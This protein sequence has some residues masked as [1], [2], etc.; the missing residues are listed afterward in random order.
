M[1]HKPLRKDSI[2]IVE[3]E[4]RIASSISTALTGAGYDVTWVSDG[5][6]GLRTALSGGFDLVVL[7]V[8]LPGMKGFDIL[9]EL[10]AAGSPLLVLVLTS[11][12][13]VED[14][15]RGLTD[16]ADDYLTKPF[17]LEELMARIDALMRRIG[18]PAHEES[19]KLNEVKLRVGNVSLNRV[20][21]EVTVGG[22]KLEL[23][24]REFD[25]LVYLMR[26]PNAVRPRAKI[27]NALWSYGSQ[28]GDHVLDVYVGRLRNRLADAGAPGFIE[29]VRGVG[30]RVI[31]TVLTEG[32][33]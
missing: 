8:M 16:G 31:G 26:V 4:A 7:D 11:R 9:R 25:L 32:D 33:E 17:Y 30:Y 20:R 1:P 15:V 23:T 14:R 29:T 27:I 22:N 10:R 28:S 6:D 18:R 3:D 5:R 19:G 2:L 24:T 13:G 12:D 21:R